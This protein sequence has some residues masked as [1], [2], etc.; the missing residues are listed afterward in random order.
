MKPGR[1]FAIGFWR[2]AGLQSER[3]QEDAEGIT[4]IGFIGKD[5]PVRMA[6]NQCWSG[7]QVVSITCRQNDANGF[8]LI[9]DQSMRLCVDAS[10]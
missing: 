6:L 1:I 9:V 2:N 4:I 5:R 8:A 7:P 3:F 10:L